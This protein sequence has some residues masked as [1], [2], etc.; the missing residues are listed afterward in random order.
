[1]INGF[2]LVQ[3]WR[4]DKG[5]TRKGFVDVPALVASEP[6]AEFEYTF[7]GTTFG[8]FLAAGFDTCVLEFSIDGGPWTRKDTHTK[9]SKSLH[10][11]WPLILVDGL[12]D[13]S[14]K[15]AVRTT[16][17]VKTRTA[18]HVIHVLINATTSTASK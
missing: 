12:E 2:S 14:H 11:P 18:L 13:G 5:N 17:Q 8:L 16:D 6:G 3:R 7:E 4:P 15:I 9:W 10:L 1:M